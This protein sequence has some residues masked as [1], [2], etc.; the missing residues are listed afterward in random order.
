[1]RRI[2]LL[3]DFGYEDGFVGAVKGVLASL[4]PEVL[5]EDIGHGL[6]PGDVRKASWVVF[7]YW[8]RYPEGT[9]H[10]V[11]VDPGVGTSRRALAVGVEGR[12][13]VAP[14][15]GVLSRVLE[16]EGEWRCVALRPSGRLPPPASQT[17]HGRDLFAPAAALLAQGVPL[18]EL[19]PPV[20]DPVRFPV[21]PPKR[22]ER[23]WVGEVLEVDRFGNLATNLPPQPVARGGGLVLGTTFIP[24]AETYGG[25]GKG[26]LLVLLDSEGRLEIAVREDSAAAALG[27]AA[28]STLQVLI[29]GDSE[30]KEGG[31]CSG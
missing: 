6:P 1:M 9:V 25:V 26:S 11:V 28:G 4:A 12:F 13:M 16:G 22:E 20:E 24:W 23:G 8:K 29:P 21:P 14:D 31:E 2:T 15:N 30:E 17:F 18:E 19:G 10:M 5:V 7:R 3:T 27:L